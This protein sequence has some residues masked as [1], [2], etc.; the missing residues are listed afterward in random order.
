MHERVPQQDRQ[1]AFKVKGEGSEAE[2][3]RIER[4]RLRHRSG[5]ISAILEIVNRHTE[6]IVI[7]LNLL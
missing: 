1:A 7:L 2:V 5:L 3:I 4:L 6:R